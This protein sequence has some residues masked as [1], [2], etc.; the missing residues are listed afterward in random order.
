MRVGAARFSWRG[1][2]LRGDANRRTD[3][4]VG[5][6]VQCSMV[7]AVLLIIG[8][9]EQNPGPVVEVENTV[10]LLGTGCDRN[11]KLVIQCE[12]C[13]LWYP[14]SCAN[15]KAQAAEERGVELW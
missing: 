1:V 10:Q 6:T 11:L 9:T 8:G 13:G 7:L 2:P 14:Y 12:L 15:V 3:G 5:L 4:C